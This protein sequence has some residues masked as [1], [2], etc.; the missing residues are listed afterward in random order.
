VNVTTL[1]KSAP[2][3]PSANGSVTIKLSKFITV[4]D[5]EINELTFRKPDSDDIEDCGDIIAVIHDP[6]RGISVA[7]T[8]YKAIRLYAA[9]LAGVPPS[10]LKGIPVEDSRKIR[11]VIDDFLSE[12]EM[13]D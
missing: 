6:A 10:S 7:K 11:K 1:D 5:E 9:R 13:T 4:G 2:S 8:D 12:K 3:L